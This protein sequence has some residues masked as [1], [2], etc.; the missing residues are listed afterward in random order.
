MIAYT[1][2]H[3]VASRGVMERAGFTYERDIL[4]DHHQHVVYR[5]RR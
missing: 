2:P 5:R 3:N 1:L 4:V